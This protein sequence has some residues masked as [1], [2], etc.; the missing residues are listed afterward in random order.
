MPQHFIYFVGMV[1]RP[2]VQTKI[3]FIL[4]GFIF[5]ELVTRE[6]LRLALLAIFIEILTT[7]SNL[8]F[9]KIKHFLFLKIFLVSILMFG[10]EKTITGTVLDQDNIPLPGTSVVVKGTNNGTQTDFDGNYSITANTGD[11]LVFSY[12]GLKTVERTI[13]VSNTVDV[14][15]EE[16]TQALEEVVVTALGISR[17]K[18]SLGYATTEL[19]G[20][21]VNVPG[22]TNVIN[23]LSGKA[24]GVNITRNNNLGGST[25]VVIRGITSIN[26]DNQA[27]F[28][29]DGVP[30]NN[31]LGNLNG[32]SSG[33]G[34]YDYGNP[35]ADIDPSIIASVNILKG[36]AATALYGSRAANGAIIITTKRGVGEERLGVTIN[37]G[38]TVGRYDKDTFIKYQNEYGQS[39]FGDVTTASGSFTNGFRTTI[40]LD[41]DGIIDPLPRYNDDASY[42]PRFDPN[43]QIYQWDALVEELPSYLQKS[44]WVAAE[45]DPSTFFQTAYSVDN[46]ITFTGSNDISDFRATYSNSVQTGIIPNSEIVKNSLSATVGYDL[47]DKLNVS[48]NLNYANTRGKGRNGTGYDGANARNLM[49]NFRQWW[50]T[51]VDLEKLRNAYE[52]TGRNISWN[53]ST[54]DAEGIEFWDNPY[55][56]VNENIPEDERNRIFGN[57]SLDYKFTDWLSANARISV[58]HFDELREQRLAI[59]SV[60]V[61]SFSSYNR[62][63]SEFNYDASLNFNQNFGEDFS[64]TALVGMNIRR[65]K[66]EVLFAQTNGGLIVPNV[67]A[68]SNSLNPP[69]PPQENFD[70]VG[71]D[72]VFGSLSLGYKNFLYLDVTGR[73]DKA[74]T[75]PLDNNAF[76]YPSVSSSFVFSNLI[77][78]GWLTFGKFRANYAE[79]GNFGTSQSLISPVLLNNAGSFG[80]INLATI[81]STLRNPDLKPETTTSYE[82]GLEMAFLKNRLGFDAAVY[83]TNSTDQIIDVAVSTAT[84]F[85]RKFVNSGEIQNKGVEISLFGS[86]IK[87]EDFEWNIRA[88]WSKNQSEVLSLFEGVDNFEVAS[89]QSGVTFNATVGRPYGTLRGSNFVYENGQP[90]VNQETGAYEQ[91]EL[92]EEIGDTNPDWIGGVTNSFAY[93]NLSFSFLI[94]VRQGGDIYSLDTYYGFGTGLYPETV[95]TNPLGNP[96][97]NHLDDGGGYVFPGVAPDGT[98]NTVLA[99]VSDAVSSGGLF[100][101]LPQAYHVEDGSFVKLREVAFTYNLPSK[102]LD[103]LNLQGLSLSLTGSNL[104]IIHKNMKYSDPE[105]GFSAG[106]AQGVQIGA[107]PTTKNYGV[108]LKMEF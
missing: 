8:G 94:D 102:Y 18:K 97:R 17:E 75:L 108:N 58:D 47:S 81:S 21:Q 1:K 99:D 66:T 55:W 42:G 89:F 72:G 23:T 101:D 106:N 35:I 83:K 90:V 100:G 59:G 46:T 77:E 9:M 33:G 53:W 43:L 67:Y 4:L 13:A 20:D 71:V 52:M 105:A 98:P 34:G 70:K 28:V 11:V 37:S 31:D 32:V 64:V 24:A 14:I 6:K 50:A 104:W 29:L 45:N 40:D 41:G 3:F 61:P 93:K 38:V 88:N 27:L 2:V 76:F 79:V 25:N 60:G 39:Y 62:R 65:T 80:D 16:D 5:F 19:E 36:A 107:Y 85:D 10:Q 95:G 86:P 63:F 44:A 49:T 22:E 56:T 54:P 12:I 78:A 30:L 91:S 69:N 103:K 48:T 51:N 74:S 82:A 84:G 26:G 87:T 15:M 73:Q 92:N 7:N 57:I 68:L 96:I